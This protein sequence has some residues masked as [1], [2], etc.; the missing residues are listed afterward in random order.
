MHAPHNLPASPLSEQ[1]P[2]LNPQPPIREELEDALAEM[3]KRLTK[4][5]MQDILDQFDTDKSGTIELDEFEHMVRSNLGMAAEH[6]PC[7][8]CNPEKKKIW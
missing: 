7:R 2:K 4:S 6:C 8:L 3:G 5:E 1:D